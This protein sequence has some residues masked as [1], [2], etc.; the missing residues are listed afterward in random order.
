MPAPLF[1]MKL[2][3]L[4]RDRAFRRGPELFLH[5]RAFDDCLER[6]SLVVRSFRSALLVGC[7]DPRWPQRLRSHAGAVEAIDPGPL[8]AAAAGGRTVVEDEWASDPGRFD[9][10][11][12]IGTL[13]TVNDLPG[14]LRRLRG[15]M[16]ADALLI[17]ALAG[18]DTLPRLRS[19]MFAADRARG[20][21]SPRVHPRI[22]GP[23]LAALL[24]GCGFVMPVVDIDR[25][26]LTYE[27]LRALVH[28]LR[29]M[30]AT[31][32]LEARDRTPM[33]RTALEA[34]ERAFLGDGHGRAR[35]QV[36]I[37]NFAAWTPARRA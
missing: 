28:D 15:A 19:A 1:D 13:D 27:S 29:A 8:F 17:G 24:G 20:F 30:A 31:N 14:A 34:A 18:G 2:R 22:D 35:E 12:A 32:I 7:P 36:E 10:V 25:V 26:S 5:E 6:L 33:S 37:L 11:V 4:R 21:L 9:L 3:A 16:S 23:S